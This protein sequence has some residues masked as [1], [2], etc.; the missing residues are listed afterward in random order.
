MF[1]PHSG[2]LAT[3]PAVPQFVFFCDLIKAYFNT[4][5][6]SENECDQV[7]IN[8]FEKKKGE[9]LEFVFWNRMGKILNLSYLISIESY[10]NT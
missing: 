4:C 9:N 3:N 5:F 6:Y 10:M 7:I 2:P 8:N 1:I